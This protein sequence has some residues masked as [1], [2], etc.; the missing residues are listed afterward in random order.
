MLSSHKLRSV[1]ASSVVILLQDRWQTT[2]GLYSRRTPPVPSKDVISYT[3]IA[4]KIPNLDFSSM[5]HPD[6]L[7]I[8]DP[9][10]YCQGA[11]CISCKLKPAD[12]KLCFT[13]IFAKG[14]AFTER[15]QL[16]CPLSKYCLPLRSFVKQLRYRI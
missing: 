11:T 14:H 9:G 12:C 15:K 1:Q 16:Y 4:P 3:C 5:P 13:Y 10:F 2:A 8:L 6:S 7:I